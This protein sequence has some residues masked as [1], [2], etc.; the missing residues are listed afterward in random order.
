[1]K[2]AAKKSAIAKN[3]G[4]RPRLP[5]KKVRDKWL[6]DV[7]FSEEELAKLKGRAASEGTAWSAWVRERLGL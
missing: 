7:R 2:K 4:G 6:N 3:K 5:P 1:M